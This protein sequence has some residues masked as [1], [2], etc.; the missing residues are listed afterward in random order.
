MA[1]LQGDKQRALGHGLEAVRE[2]FIESNT[3][4]RKGGGA[5]TLSLVRSQVKHLI[6]PGGNEEARKKAEK[7]SVNVCVCVFVCVCVCAFLSLL[8]DARF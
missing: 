4:R 1:Y 8:S 2:S 5:H 3:V 6:T 7:V